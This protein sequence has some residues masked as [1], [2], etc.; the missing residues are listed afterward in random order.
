MNKQAKKYYNILYHTF[1]ERTKKEKQ[2]LSE[3]KKMLENYSYE[4]IDDYIQY[5]G[6]PQDI[7]WSYYEHLDHSF[8]I[9]KMKTHSII[10]RM[11]IFFIILGILLYSGLAYMR[12]TQDIQSQNEF[13]YYDIIEY[14]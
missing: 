4:T 2:Y 8:I 11:I 1:P 14:E 10:K 3:F 6:D 13:Y 12:Y 7:V 5:I 9:K